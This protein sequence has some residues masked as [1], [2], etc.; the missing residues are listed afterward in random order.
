[1]NN[2]MPRPNRRMTHRRNLGGT[3]NGALAVLPAPES[4]GAIAA[5]HT[6]PITINSMMPLPCRGVFL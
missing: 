6:L 4:V 5:C 1:M 3:E 2:R